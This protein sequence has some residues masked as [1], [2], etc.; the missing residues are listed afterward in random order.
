[1]R[2]CRSSGDVTERLFRSDTERNTAVCLCFFLLRRLEMAI[3]VS[4]MRSSR[5]VSLVGSEGLR[6]RR[7]TWFVGKR[8]NCYGDIRPNGRPEE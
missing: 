2:L 7:S 4:F 6:P 8:R 3:L 1:M 5:R